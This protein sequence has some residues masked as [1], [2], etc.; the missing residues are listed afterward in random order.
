MVSIRLLEVVGW[1]VVARVS[2]GGMDLTRN[3]SCGAAKEAEW[4]YTYRLGSYGHVVGLLH[5]LGML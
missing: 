2:G 3:L 1:W 4:G 5:A